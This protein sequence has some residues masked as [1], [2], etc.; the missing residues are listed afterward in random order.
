MVCKTI[1]VDPYSRR[2]IWELLLKYKKGRTVI[3]T[4]HFMD[5]ADILGDRIAIISQGKL[6]ALGSS[7][8][9]KT[10]FGQGYTLHVVKRDKFISACESIEINSEPSQKQSYKHSRLIEKFV[11][12]L[13][14]E[15]MMME[16]VGSEVSFLLPYPTLN[17]FSGLFAE[18][19]KNM[20]SLG[21]LSY[22]ISDTSLED[23]FLKITMADLMQNAESFHA[24]SSV[25]KRKIMN[26]INTCKNRLS[27][28]PNTVD[29]RVLP[30]TNST[31]LSVKSI[32]SHEADY[33]K[34]TDVDGETMYSDRS[35]VNA[36][37]LEG[38]SID[39]SEGSCAALEVEAV[40]SS[41][42]DMPYECTNP[43]P[44]RSCLSKRN[45]RSC[46]MPCVQIYMIILKRLWNSRRNIKAVFFEV[47]I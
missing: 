26:M 34:N 42:L 44:N 29:T 7:L 9:L 13:I 18:L 24:L 35:T 3:L 20:E 19:E 27:K 2:S 14:P 8:Y 38:K 12:D 40:T 31:A 25:C 28:K 6:K 36:S 43:V 46:C 23:V 45:R 41:L 21:I 1:G 15:A 30:T 17:K 4:T 37:I 22:G 33:I 11:R 47:N 5:E 32:V 39:A 16:Y 10:N